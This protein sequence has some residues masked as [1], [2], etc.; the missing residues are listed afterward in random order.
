MKKWYAVYTQA[1]GEIK[2]AENLRRQGYEVYLPQ[3]MRRIRHARRVDWNLSPLFPR[4]LFVSIDID[5]QGWRSIQSTIGVTQMVCS[6]GRPLAVPSGV[7]GALRAR[8]NDRGAIVMGPS[9]TYRPGD[10]VQILFGAFGDSLAEFEKLDDQDRVVLLLDLM[11]RRV[12]IKT[13]LDGI[14]AVG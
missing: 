5:G 9:K 11:G 6:G 8:E 4:Y 7:V 2:A 13:S 10:Q 12:K 14:A 3:F 1:R